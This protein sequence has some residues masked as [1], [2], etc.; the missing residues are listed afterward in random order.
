MIELTGINDA[1]KEMEKDR[2]ELREKYGDSED[3]RILH[4]FN[5]Y[6]KKTEE[7]LKTL[8]NERKKVISND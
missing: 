7:W 2:R 8:K 6:F 3:K 5:E 4:M 1:I